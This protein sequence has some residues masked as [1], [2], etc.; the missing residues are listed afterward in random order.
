L[1]VSSFPRV[2]HDVNLQLLLSAVRRRARAGGSATSGEARCRV[3]P[4]PA[5]SREPRERRPHNKQRARAKSNWAYLSRGLP[6]C[7]YRPLRNAKAW[8]TSG[9]RT[10]TDE[11][12]GRE[13]SSCYPG[14]CPT[15]GA[16]STVVTDAAESIGAS[17]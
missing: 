6:V 3:R 7:T 12:C 8:R 13:D 10:P 5:R 17:A 2:A 9:T 1:V 16:P 4:E 15:G 11:T 14:R